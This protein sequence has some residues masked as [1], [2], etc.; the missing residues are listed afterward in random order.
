MCVYLS[1][2]VPE[3]RNTNPHWTRLNLTSISRS[4]DG[5][6]EIHGK[7]VMALYFRFLFSISRSLRTAFFSLVTNE[8]YS[9]G[10]GKRV[11]LHMW[12]WVCMS[13]HF[14]LWLY[15][16]RIGYC[17]VE[18]FESVISLL[19]HHL[20]SHLKLF[21]YRAIERERETVSSNSIEFNCLYFMI[22]KHF[23]HRNKLG[24]V[25]DWWKT[26]RAF[27]WKCI[28][29]LM[30]W[31]QNLFNL[32]TFSVALKSFRWKIGLFES[33]SVGTGVMALAWHGVASLF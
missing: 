19:L 16:M 14:M 23:M 6:V 32:F 5:R 9:D 2:F 25:I 10:D 28:N 1:V 13:V 12:M 7:S 30:Y 17:V 21:A 20:Y 27:T 26:N 4:I 33:S 29:Q 3:L 24:D 8:R 18:R 15:L 11:W 31:C 22:S